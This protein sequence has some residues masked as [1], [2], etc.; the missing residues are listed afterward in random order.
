MSFVRDAT[1]FLAGMLFPVILIV[2]GG[3]VVGLGITYQ[4]TIVLVVG[5]CILGAG[6]LWGAYHLYY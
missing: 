5:L 3:L 1:R 4:M 6:V 2:I